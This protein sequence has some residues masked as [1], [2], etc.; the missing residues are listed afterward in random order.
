M[1]RYLKILILIA[2]FA[3][4]SEVGAQDTINVKSKNYSEYHFYYRDSIFH[5]DSSKNFVINVNVPK[6]CDVVVIHFEGY[7]LFDS[8]SSF[9]CR[10][11]DGAGV[12]SWELGKLTK[13]R[14]YNFEYKRGWL[15]KY[16]DVLKKTMT[17]EYGDGAKHYSKVVF[18]NICR[19]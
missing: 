6:Q 15:S 14:T 8:E 2:S 4:S 11:S 10:G 17:I 7:A 16:G 12:P 13:G 3:F 5:T 19:L 9:N 1:K 18:F